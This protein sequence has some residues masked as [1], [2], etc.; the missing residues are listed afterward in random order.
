MSCVKFNRSLPNVFFADDD[1]IAGYANYQ[2]C[3]SI[4]PAFR[5]DAFGI[6]C[7][8]TDGSRIIIDGARKFTKENEEEAYIKPSDMENEI[9]SWVERLN[10]TTLCYDC[11]LVLN[12]VEKAE[13]EWGITTVKNVVGEKEYGMWLSLNDGIGEFDLDITYNEYAKR[14]VDQLVKLQLPSGKIRVDHPYGG[15]KDTCDSICQTIYYLSQN[16][17]GKVWSPIGHMATMR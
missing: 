15:S 13:D 11:D 1:V 7:G 6:A 17:I 14:E 2:H 3:L 4:D 9:S 5:N 8:Y 16:N 12:I 10:V